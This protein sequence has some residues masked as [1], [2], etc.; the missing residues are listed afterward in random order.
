MDDTTR[1]YV[2]INSKVFTSLLLAALETYPKESAGLLFGYQCLEPDN[3]EY[4]VWHV[5]PHQLVYHRDEDSI[6]EDYKAYLRIKGLHRK[7]IGASI[8]GG[9]HSHPDST[10][11]LSHDDKEYILTKPLH[12]IELVVGIKPIGNEGEYWTLSDDDLLIQ[13]SFPIGDIVYD[14]NIAGY[15]VIGK[16]FYRLGLRCGYIELLDDLTQ[17][18]FPNLETIGD[19]YEQARLLGKD[20]YDLF[21]LLSQLENNLD[22]PDSKRKE[23]VLEIKAL[24]EE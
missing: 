2:F 22:D 16:K 15:Y 7:L 14:V 19:L 12:K 9:F 18:A 17:W 3:I 21:D 5:V 11:I 13:G 20:V 24:I 6:D 23:I 4:E 10:P 8:L 1:R